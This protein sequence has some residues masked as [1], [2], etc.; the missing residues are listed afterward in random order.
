MASLVRRAAS[1]IAA[2]FNQTGDP[3]ATLTRVKIYCKAVSGVAQL[4]AQLSD[5]TV[6]QMT[7]GLGARQLVPELWAVNQIAISQTNV[8][9]S[10]DLSQLF[11]TWTT[12]RAGSVIGLRTKLDTPV[13]AGT[14]TLTVAVNGTPG[15]LNV[16]ST[17]GSNPS[18]GLSTQAV[19]AAD[20]FVASDT[21]SVVYTSS[22]TFAPTTL[23]AE[24]YL[25]I[26]AN[27]V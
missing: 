11:D 9:M 3:G 4:F 13:T 7:P 17:S 6:I 25:E 18:G 24:A 5:G 1:G 12:F 20:T 23:N 8:A 22:G 2:F 21:L 10:V 19:A 15:T 26:Y 16:V 14:L 27:N